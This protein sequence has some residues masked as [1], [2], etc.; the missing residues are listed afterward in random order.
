M[1]ALWSPAVSWLTSMSCR[2]GPPP[3]QCLAD[4]EVVSHYG[5]INATGA[6]HHH[7]SPR[8]PKV[9]ALS[10][11]RGRLT[12]HEACAHVRGPV[13]DALLTRTCVRYT[14]VGALRT[15]G[16][17]VLHTPGRLTAGVH[18]SVFYPAGNPTTD[19]TAPWPASVRKAFDRCFNEHVRHDVE[20]GP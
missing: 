7:S 8:P 11:H 19:Q 4:D 3:E 14:T 17:A 15:A 12:P 20:T 2:C 13:T 9:P 6:C 18:C 10:V 16:F 1:Q 5:E